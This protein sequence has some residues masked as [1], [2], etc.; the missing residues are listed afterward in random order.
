LQTILVINCGSATLKYRLLQWPSGR[1]LHAG[2]IDA[3]GGALVPD[4]A[5][6]IHHMVDDIRVAGYDLHQLDAV[7]HRVVHGGGRFHAPARIDA[8]VLD[9]IRAAIPLAPLH[10]PASLA[11]IES[12][13]A[14]VPELPQVAAFD[15]AFH[16]GMPAV[17][18][19]YALPN[20][21]YHDHGVRRYG[22]HGCS[23]EY[24]AQEAAKQL[25]RPLDELRLITLH[26]GNGASAAAIRH[27]RSID[28]SM[29][30]TPLEGLV[31]GSRCGD[32]DP[33]IL[34][35]LRRDGL[36]TEEVERLLTHQAGLRGVSGV[37]DM[38]EVLLRAHAG[39][40]DAALARDLFVYRLRKYIGAYFAILGGLDALIFTGGI[41][42]HSAEIRA[43]CCAEM[44]HLGLAL[45][46]D[47]NSAPQPDRISH[48][49]SRAAILVVPTNEELA[50]ARQ[51]ASLLQD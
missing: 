40:A 21:L 48:A 3:I 5:T 42:E 16:L 29:G 43:R 44:E 39:D 34:F 6:A 24:V 14:L 12:L 27:G 15:T 46:A 50:I 8:E 20:S 38:R 31:M 37:G 49:N 13:V 10:N 22:F 30:M 26:L 2:L 9:A 35:Y 32:L 36:S 47:R 25:H 23:H 7:G 17:A 4:H 51:V 1:A 28:T 18:H 41:G 45:D 33:G 19:R 11:A